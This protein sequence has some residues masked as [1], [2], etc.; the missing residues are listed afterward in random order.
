ML[1]LE[2]LNDFTRDFTATE[3]EVHVNF[4]LKG[5][6]HRRLRQVKVENPQTFSFAFAAIV[7]TG[8]DAGAGDAVSGWSVS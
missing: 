7:F 3:E 2:Q 1:V 5:R 4:V 6:M 8:V